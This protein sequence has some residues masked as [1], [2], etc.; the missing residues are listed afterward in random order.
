MERISVRDLLQMLCKLPG[1]GGV[2]GDEVGDAP[3]KSVSIQSLATERI[4]GSDHFCKVSRFSALGVFPL[5]PGEAFIVDLVFPGFSSRAIRVAQELRAEE[6]V[7]HLYKDRVIHT[8][9]MITNLQLH[10]HRVWFRETDHAVAEI[11]S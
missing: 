4:V 2:L 11:T 10:E 6:R 3:C 8:D 5:K 7:E 9:P 1:T